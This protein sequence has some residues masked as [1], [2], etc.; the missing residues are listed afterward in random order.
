MVEG[1]REFDA[2]HVSLYGNIQPEK[3][4]ELMGDEGRHG[5]NGQR[6]LVC[7]SP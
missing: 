2:S 6:V 4:A 5:G 7:S 1:V 3:L